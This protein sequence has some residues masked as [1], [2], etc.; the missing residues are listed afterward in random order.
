MSKRV[1]IGCQ[2]PVSS[3]RKR[4]ESCRKA[5][6]AADMRERRA[7]ESGHENS[8]HIDTAHVVD[9]TSGGH[10]PPVFDVVQTPKREAAWPQ[11]VSDGRVESPVVRERHRQL[12]YSA[13]PAWVRMDRERAAKMARKNMDEKAREGQGGPLGCDDL[14]ATQA[15]GREGHVVDFSRATFPAGQP[16]PPRYDALGRPF[17][18]PRRWG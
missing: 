18:R 6:H 7:A 15:E 4:C 14:M 3:R 11:P 17:P 8:D 5:A 9:Y 13:V 16:G 1:C 2:Q 12:D 10:G